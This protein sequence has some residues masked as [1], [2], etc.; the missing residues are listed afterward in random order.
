M[1]SLQSLILLPIPGTLGIYLS[2]QKGLSWQLWWEAHTKA[3]F[4]VHPIFPFLILLFQPLLLLPC[5]QQIP[6]HLLEL[7][8]HG[9]WWSWLFSD[10]HL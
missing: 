5:L 6:G 2:P 1:K 3:V 4:L 7:Q 10:G 9:L 8:L